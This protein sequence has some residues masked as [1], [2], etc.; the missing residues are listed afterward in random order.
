[1][2][3]INISSSETR[4]LK[5]RCLKISHNL[6]IVCHSQHIHYMK[7]LFSSLLTIDSLEKI[8]EAFNFEFKTNQITGSNYPQEIYKLTDKQYGSISDGF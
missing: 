5:M 4:S 1:M 8:T 3:G 6:F 2:Y 7:P